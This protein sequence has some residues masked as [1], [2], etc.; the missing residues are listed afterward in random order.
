MDRFSDQALQSLSEAQEQIDKQAQ[1][2]QMLRIREF[3]EAE[4]ARRELDRQRQ[5]REE[6]QKMLS[7]LTDV[8]H[9]ALHSRSKKVKFPGTCQWIFSED[10]FSSWLDSSLSATFVC[11]GIPCSGK[12]VLASSITDRLSETISRAGRNKSALCVHYCTHLDQRSLNT[13]SIIGSLIRQLLEAIEIPRELERDLTAQQASTSG[14]TFDALTDILERIC[15]L[16]KAVY[17]V[18]DGLD[19]LQL[20]NQKYTINAIRKCGTSCI[21][22]TF[23]TSRQE[24]P[25]IRHALSSAQS[26]ELSSKT[27][28]NDIELFV[29]GAIEQ[30]VN[31]GALIGL[32]LSLK[33]DVIAALMNGAENMCVCDD[34]NLAR[35]DTNA[36][37]RFFWVKLQIDELCTAQ[38]P[39][40]VRSILETLP[41]DLES[42]FE[43][44]VWKIASSSQGERKLAT[45][46]RV[47]RWIMCAT[48]PLT[49]EELKEAFAIDQEDAYLERDKV[50]SDDGARL[51]ES[52]GNFIV[53]HRE[54]YTVTIAHHSIEQFLT[55]EKSSGLPLNLNK[56]EMQE[57]TANHVLTYLLFS[58]F[59]TQITTYRGH[60]TVDTRSLRNAL[61]KSLP[62]S[63]TFRRIIETLQSYAS[64]S[65]F[66]SHESVRVNL[67]QQHQSGEGS[68]DDSLLNTYH[69][70]EYVLSH[71]IHHTRCIPLT[72]ARLELKD[73]NDNALWAKFR[74]VALEHN[75]AFAIRPWRSIT[76]PGFDIVMNDDYS[77]VEYALV[78]GHWPLL[79]LIKSYIGL[80]RTSSCIERC[81][82]K[83]LVHAL[84]NL[85]Q[86][87]D[88][89]DELQSLKA[90]IVVPFKANGNFLTSIVL[91]CAKH[92]YET[93]SRFY[94]DQMITKGVRG[95]EDQV[96]KPTSDFV[97]S[98]Q[99]IRD[100]T[101]ESSL[102]NV[103]VNLARGLLDAEKK[104]SKSVKMTSRLLVGLTTRDNDL[105]KFKIS[106]VDSLCRGIHGKLF[107]SHSL[108]TAAGSASSYM[109]SHL[110]DRFSHEISP[111]VWDAALKNFVL[112]FLRSWPLGV[113]YRFTEVTRDEADEEASAIEATSQ[114]LYPPKDQDRFRSELQRAARSGSNPDIS[115]V[116]QGLDGAV[117]KN[118]EA[119]L[120]AL[121]LFSPSIVNPH[122]IRL[123]KMSATDSITKKLFVKQRWKAL[124]E[125]DLQDSEMDL[126]S[127]RKSLDTTLPSRAPS[128]RETGHSS[129]PI[130]ASQGF[131]IKLIDAWSRSA[132][133]E[134]L[135]V[136]DA[137]R[138]FR[139]LVQQYLNRP[140]SSIRSLDRPMELCALK[141]NL[142]FSRAIS[143]SLKRSIPDAT[144]DQKFCI[145]NLPRCFE[146]YREIPLEQARDVFV[147]LFEAE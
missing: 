61:T 100:F 57:T 99:E 21:L 55:S 29:A 64:L 133:D 52:C 42:T 140:D 58:D 71:W 85:Y 129:A 144:V 84:S 97:P 135:E 125:S 39:R 78:Q 20:E 98:L 1:V 16:F 32:D 5:A 7:L 127:V 110:C 23:V 107:L 8:D 83:A 25:F 106:I 91:S 95:G 63:S 88:P 31:C 103:T 117:L 108:Q 70:L 62:F 109:V 22:K 54:D 145:G 146:I 81:T 41:R 47:L 116:R 33:A 17:L 113:R 38:N 93:V 87:P 92:S 46:R 72:K 142:I 9:K 86:V 18:L 37:C 30:K 134:L 26:M 51:L 120:D 50:P 2:A 119:L 68:V 43:R 45:A 4:N 48:R 74:Q 49:T 130:H 10:S 128:S 111:A 143:A 112:G 24:E 53:F 96:S 19:E 14:A 131:E 139:T 35:R 59:E 104:H 13:C 141:G 67:L 36:L 34:E 136:D 75:F 137:D 89:C 60:P 12:T 124:L 94:V 69:L 82:H 44:I 118:H 122:L 79:L 6:R 11:Y 15:C 56:S 27:L 102:R 123:V 76:K 138:A 132:P 147:D 40:E 80:P 90:L 73:P 121:L 3:H 105:Q 126:S 115:R 66:E 77:I 65:A 114:L 28:H 101:E